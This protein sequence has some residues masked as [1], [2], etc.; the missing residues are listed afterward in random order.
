MEQGT[1]PFTY[2]RIQVNTGAR[3][4]QEILENLEVASLDA[5]GTIGRHT[6]RAH[7]RMD[8]V[9]ILSSSTFISYTHKERKTIQPAP[10]HSSLVSMPPGVHG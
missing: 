7:K 8:L 4:V 2:P 3:P 9:R 5:D 1:S 6:D 10:D